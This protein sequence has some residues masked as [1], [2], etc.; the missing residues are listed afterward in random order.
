M[1]IGALSQAA[2][3]HAFQTV[4][5]AAKWNNIMDA[6]G[7]QPQF[8]QYGCLLVGRKGLV[9]SFQ[10]SRTLYTATNGL[11]FGCYYRNNM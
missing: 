4:T 11:F 1:F 10:E 5:K 8:P 7:T 9:N 3:A 2:I 6:F